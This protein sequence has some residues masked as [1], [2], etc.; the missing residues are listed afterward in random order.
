MLLS[1]IAEAAG[2]LN[3]TCWMT[4]IVWYHVG[5]LSNS[6]QCRASRRRCPASVLALHSV[7]FALCGVCTGSS[8]VS[9]GVAWITQIPRELSVRHGADALVCDWACQPAWD[10]AAYTLVSRWLHDARIS[11]SLFDITRRSRRSRTA[12]PPASSDGYNP[13][14]SPTLTW[15]PRVTLHDLD[16][17]ST[18]VPFL[19]LADTWDVWHSGCWCW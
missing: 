2:Y 4:G 10:I 18:A 8:E 19:H 14:T 13:E 11:M 12:P 5:R 15:P 3:L 1:D 16:L 6:C 7:G 17:T 9:A